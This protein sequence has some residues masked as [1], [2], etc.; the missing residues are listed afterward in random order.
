M[1][2]VKIV[3]LNFDIILDKTADMAFSPEMLI[4]IERVKDFSLKKN[5]F[6]VSVHHSVEEKYTGGYL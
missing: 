5:T 1:P 4:K 6:K 2:F 3:I